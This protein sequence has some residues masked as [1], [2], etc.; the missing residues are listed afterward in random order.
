MS[1]E[2]ILNELKALATP[3][4]AKNPKDR[5][6]RDRYYIWEYE[7]F[8]NPSGGEGEEICI[9]D[10][11]KLANNEIKDG[12]GYDFPEWIRN[13]GKN[14]G[15]QVNDSGEICTLV[16]ISYTYRDYYYILESNGHKHFTTC[17]ATIDIL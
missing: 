14:F 6:Y 15:K 17:L 5:T 9:Y 7:E 8:L 16:G 10:G 3:A 13:C 2:G 12:F 4:L 1:R 11:T